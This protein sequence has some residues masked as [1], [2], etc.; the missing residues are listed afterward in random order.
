MFLKFI[1][2]KEEL[3]FLENRYKNKGFESIVIYGRRRVGKTELIKEFIKNKEHLYFLCDKGGTERNAIRFKKAVANYFN[4]PTIESN[5]FEEIFNYMIEKLKK[6]TVIVF[7]EF[8]YLV[9]KDSTIPSI[10]Q[11]I[12][13]EILKDKDVI[14]ILCG[15]SI[16]MMEEGVLSKKSSLY[17]RKTGHW[18]VLPFSLYNSSK[19]F[20]T[21]PQEKNI[22]FWSILGGIPY[23]LEKFSDKISTLEN[24]RHEILSR[25]GRLYEEI[26]FILKEELREPD[27]Y[28]S[29]LEAIGTGKTKVNEIADKSRIKVQDMDKYLKV[30]LKLG[31]IRK[32]LPVTEKPKTKKTIYTFE[33][34]FFYF[35][36]RFCEQYKSEVEIGEIKNVIEKVKKELN[37]FIGN[38][39]EKICKNLLSKL[40]NINFKKIGRWWGA[41]RENGERRTAEIDVVALND[42]NREILFCECKW[43][44]NVNAEKVLEEL[45]QKSTYVNWNNEKRN[46]YFAI[47]AKTFRGRIKE[48]NLFLF[49]L[50][51]IKK[52]FR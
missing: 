39:F 31:I 27:V 10:F 48:E 33:D 17:G 14:L 38:R 36:F 18:K 6:R 28:R 40:S 12:L 22:E 15:S 20:I 26:D 45:K 42:D 41:Y 7:D 24:I 47:F 9:E 13:D 37:S 35:W 25:E 2:R 44:D 4:E 46:E 5:D 8:S 3:A 1:N 21:S 51:D 11:V 49:D 16:S 50:E 30:L 34:N 19:F 43:R 52:A 23:Y 29:I 32:D